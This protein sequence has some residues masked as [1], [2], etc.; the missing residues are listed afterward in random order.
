MPNVDVPRLCGGTFFTQ[1]L[2]MKKA[3]TRSQEDALLGIRDEVNNQRTLEALIKFFKPDF[4]VYSDSTF[5]GMVSGYRSCQEVSG[6]YLPFTD[7]YADIAGFDKAV[8]EKYNDTVDMMVD[9]A[10]RFIDCEKE[11]EKVYPA[12]K[13]LLQTV[14]DDRSIADDELFYMWRPITKEELCNETTIILEPFLLGLWHFIVLKRQDN[15]VGKTTFLSWC[16]KNSKNDRWRYRSEFG[17]EYSP[18]ILIKRLDGEILNDSHGQTAEEILDED[19]TE[20]VSDGY[21]SPAFENYRTVLQQIITN[22][23]YGAPGSTNIQTN[24]GNVTINAYPVHSAPVIDKSDYYHLVVGYDFSTR[25]RVAADRALKEYISEDV[26]NTFPL[27]NTD[28]MADI[29]VLVMPEINNKEKEQIVVMGTITK[30]KSQDNGVVLY[31]QK[32]S[33]FLVETLV[34]NME[35]FGV[36]HIFE[37]NR[38][39][40]TIKKIN[41]EE[42]MEDAANEE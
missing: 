8:K 3:S 29:P 37:L 22:N 7:E 35:L 19:T 39:H 26:K 5:K 27:T 11:E 33:T 23:F 25:I 41:L 38:T 4:V 17:K 16:Y 12:I 10:N 18:N 2:R 9:F 31:A 24:Y 14:K 36:D 21:T 20:Y 34:N 13:A 28:S 40:W 32:N 42:A 30:V 1:I 6:E 15:S